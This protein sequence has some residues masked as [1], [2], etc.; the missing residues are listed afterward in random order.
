MFFV[1]I[2]FN[3][4]FE[5]EDIE[6]FFSDDIYGLERKVLLVLIKQLKDKLEVGLKKREKRFFK[7]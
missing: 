6:K 7:E 3:V 1:K 4:L 5:V 2:D